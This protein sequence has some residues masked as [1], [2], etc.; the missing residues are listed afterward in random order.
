M[1]TVRAFPVATV[2]TEPLGRLVKEICESFKLWSELDG[3]ERLM[4]CDN[5]SG[6]LTLIRTRMA[7]FGIDCQEEVINPQECIYCV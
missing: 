3:L 4:Q 5:I 6:T 7:Q 1:A 2:T